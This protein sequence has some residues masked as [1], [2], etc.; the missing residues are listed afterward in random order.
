MDTNNSKTTSENKDALIMFSY[1]SV[2]RNNR[3]LYVGDVLFTN[4][5]H[6]T[7]AD[8]EKK[9]RSSMVG[10]GTFHPERVGMMRLS[11]NKSLRHAFYEVRET[12]ANGFPIQTRT[13]SEL[14]TEIER[15]HKA[16]TVA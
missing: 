13:I 2:N 8:I 4:P 1:V 5:D 15:T 6:L 9:I 14:I 10:W 16:I 11:K 12:I 7:R 3:P